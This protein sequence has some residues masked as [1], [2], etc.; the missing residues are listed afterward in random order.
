VG[1]AVRLD[2]VLGCVLSVIA[3]VDVMAM[4]EVSVMC[5]RLMVS[6]GVVLGGFAVM[7]RSVLMVLRCLVVMMRGFR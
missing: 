5:C 1:V 3:G 2:V 6:I 7:T 4:S